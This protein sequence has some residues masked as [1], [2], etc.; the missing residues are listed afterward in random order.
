MA[1][2]RKAGNMGYSHDWWLSESIPPDT[3]E[4]IRRDSEKLIRAFPEAI[5]GFWIDETEIG[6]N[7]GCE[8]FF[9]SREG[10][11]R[12]C[13]KTYHAPCDKLVCAILSVAKQY[14]PGL[15]VSSDALMGSE[16]DGWPEACAWAT[17]VLGRRIC[18]PW[19][20]SGETLNGGNS[21]LE[22]IRDHQAHTLFADDMTHSRPSRFRSVWDSALRLLDFN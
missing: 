4:L 20:R 10:Q 6:F 13:C 7:G 18:L 22:I 3:W 15:S 21:L 2:E 12:G 19:A 1:K 8:T 17:D 9:L 5:E 11:D 14:H 16:P